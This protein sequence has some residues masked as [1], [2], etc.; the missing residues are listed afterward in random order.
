L[1]NIDH[2]V[3]IPPE[4]QQ[5]ILER[6]YIMYND[7]RVNLVTARQILQL[8][9]IYEKSDDINVIIF[10]NRTNFYGLIVD[11]LWGIRDLII[12]PVNKCLGKIKDISSASMLEDG[13]PVFILDIDD[14]ICSMDLLIS[15]KRLYR[16]EDLL[17]GHEIENRKRILVADDSIT[18][19]E[20]VRKILTDKGYR[21][22][23]AVDGVD[24]WN[25]LQENT[26]D[27]IVTDVDMPRMDGIELVHMVKNDPKHEWL[28]IIIVSYKDREEDRQ[29]GLD[30]GADYYLTKSSF[31]NDTF[32]NVVQDLISNPEK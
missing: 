32:A 26:Y 31:Q 8:A 15:E 5:E 12:Q 14:M 22:D 28:P 21:V 27:L 18:V 13:T 25:T 2:I 23:V 10:S 29:R 24:T 11:R 7:R 30:A 9:G 1:V 20:A 17:P 4:E 19:R 16:I 3:K 6:Q